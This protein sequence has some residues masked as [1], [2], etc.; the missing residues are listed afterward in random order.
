MAY[1]DTGHAEHAHHDV[2]YIAVFIALCIFTGLSVLADVV[3]GLPYTV[4]VVLVLSISTAKALCVMLF[5]MHLKFEGAWKYILLAPTTILAIGLPIA[6]IPDIGT[7]YYI[8]AVPQDADFEQ[9]MAHHSSGHEESGHAEQTQGADPPPTEEATLSTPQ[10]EEP[11]RSDDS[12]AP[13]SQE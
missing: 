12:P 4:K 9:A 2:K 5:F 13:E 10:Q 7:R 3:E 11:G 8:S 6:L 1:R